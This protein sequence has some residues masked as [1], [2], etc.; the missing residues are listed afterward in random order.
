MVF[1]HGNN[2]PGPR[3]IPTERLSGKAVVVRGPVEFA[4]SPESRSPKADMKVSAIFW[5]IGLGWRVG[6]S[7]M[8][9]GG[10]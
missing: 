6:R 3:A 7:E 9:K 10:P 2:N 4:R 5:P 8:E 1:E